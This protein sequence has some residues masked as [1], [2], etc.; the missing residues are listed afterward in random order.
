MAEIASVVVNIA[1]VVKRVLD[2]VALCKVNTVAMSQIKTKL[3]TIL[4]ILDRLNAL[5]AE[6]RRDLQDAVK[7]VLAIVADVE[8]FVIGLT[9]EPKGKF[10]KIK[11]YFNKA[12]RTV[13][14]EAIQASLADLENKLQRQLIDLITAQ[15]ASQLKKQDEMAKSLD[16]ISVFLFASGVAQ[17]S[18]ASSQTT[19]NPF[20]EFHDCEIRDQ[21]VVSMPGVVGTRAVEPQPIATSSRPP[22]HPPAQP[23]SDS[24][25][26]SESEARPLPMSD[27]GSDV[28]SVTVPVDTGT[29]LSDA[30]ADLFLLYASND[31][32]PIP[33][34]HLLEIAAH[35]LICGSFVVGCALLASDSSKR[36]SVMLTL[37]LLPVGFLIF[38][39]WCVEHGKLLS[40]LR[41]VDNSAPLQHIRTWRQS[42]TST[43]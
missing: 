15:G 8:A 12:F 23:A 42:A 21:D 16:R 34:L 30:D 19:A 35:Q 28:G 5:P 13:S 37:P 26:A 9:K 3:R 17:R 1:L 33:A 41:V 6:D 4:S 32:Q 10:I 14:A 20:R 27:V 36:I 24:V 39:M 38:A 40:S 22:T 7:G 2:L 43:H 18:L 25:S 29:A 11:T 31:D